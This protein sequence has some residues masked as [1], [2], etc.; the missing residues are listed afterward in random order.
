MERKI[1]GPIIPN[2][3]YT[4]IITKENVPGNLFDAIK[5]TEDGRKESRIEYY[6]HGIFEYGDIMEETYWVYIRWLVTQ[7]IEQVSPGNIPQSQELTQRLR[8]ED[9]KHIK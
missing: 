3:G 5:I 6:L 7:D 1:T 9:Y 8:S 4:F 2:K